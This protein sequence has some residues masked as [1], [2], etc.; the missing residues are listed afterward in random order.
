M[1]QSQIRPQ[2]VVEDVRV[3]LD[4]THLAAELLRAERLCA[5]GLHRVT[6][7][8]LRRDP[9]LTVMREEA[10]QAESQR[11]LSGA[12]GPGDQQILTR[13]ELYRDSTAHC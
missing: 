12:A 1:G 13:C 7:H 3:L 5:V 9:I 8:R 2:R 4:Q 6:G 11:A 10:R